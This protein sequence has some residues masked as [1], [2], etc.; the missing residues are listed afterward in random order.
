MFKGNSKMIQAIK[1]NSKSINLFYLKSAWNT[2]PTSEDL[3]KI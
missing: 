3:I 2:Q 1:L